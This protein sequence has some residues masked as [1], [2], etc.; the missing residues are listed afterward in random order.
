[1][2][3][4]REVGTTVHARTQRGWD[5]AIRERQ[6][7]HLLTEDSPSPEMASGSGISHP[8]CPHEMLPLAVQRLYLKNHCVRAIELNF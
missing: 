6:T 5:R 8:H 2:L 3:R 4:G 1:M 7:H